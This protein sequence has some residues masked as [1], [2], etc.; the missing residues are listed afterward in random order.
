MY[1][2]FKTP[3]IWLFVPMVLLNQ[4][5]TAGDKVDGLPHDPPHD[6]ADIEDHPGKRPINTIFNLS[7]RLHDM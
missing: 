5:L 1:K 4:F 3:H 6:Y 7:S 2:T